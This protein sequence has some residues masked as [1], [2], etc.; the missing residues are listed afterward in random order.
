MAFNTLIFIIYSQ[1]IVMV[2]A[3]ISQRPD[4]QSSTFQMVE[5]I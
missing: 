4:I 2:Y 3:R 1:Y 5:E